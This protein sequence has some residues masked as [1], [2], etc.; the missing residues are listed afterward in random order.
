MMLHQSQSQIAKDLHRFRVVNCGRR[1]GKA[2]AI[3]TPI[4][5]TQGFKNLIDIEIGD[6]VFDENGKQV[7]V[8]YKSE[9]YNNRNCYA[10]TFSDGSVIIA[11]ENHDWLVED[12]SYRK[13]ITRSGKVKMVKLTTKQIQN[14]L[15]YG[16]ENNFS[17]PL[18]KPLEL[19][20]TSLSIE[21]YFLGLWLGDGSSD[22]CGITTIDKEVIDYLDKYADRLNCKLRIGGTG[23]AKT[24]FITGSRKQSDRNSSLQSKLRLL[25]VLNNKHIPEEFY[26]SSFE[27]RTELL[28]GL[29]DSDGYAGNNSNEY[30]TISKT[31]AQDVNKLL[32]SLSIK[33]TVKE[34]NSLFYGRIIGKKYRIHFNTDYEVFRLKRKLEK[35]HKINRPWSKRRY[36]TNVIGVGSVPV[37][38]LMVNSESHLFLAGYSLIPTHNTTLAVLEMVGKAVYNNDIQI[39][40]IAPTFDQAR[41]IAW[42]ELIKIVNQ[43]AI[44]INESRLEVT[45]R[46]TKGGKSKISLRGWEAV[47]RLRGKKF[48]FLVIDEIASM[49]NWDTNWEEVLR[50]TLTDTRGHAL[51]IST[52]KGFNH[53]Y[54]LFNKEKE[55]KDYK[56]F[57]YTSYDNP[58]LPVDE[59]DK[60]KTEMT[61]DRF[62]QEYLA[63]FR[64]MEGLVYKEFNRD[65]HLYSEEEVKIVPIEKFSGID[66]GYVNPCAVLTIIK[67][68]DNKFW[69]DDEFYKVKKSEE[70][71]AEYV[72]SQSFS[73]VYPDPEA[74]SAIEALRKKGVGVREVIKNRDSIKNGIDKIRELFKTNRLKINRRCVNLILELETYSYPDKK[75]LRNPDENPIKEN[76]HALDALRYALYMQPGASEIRPQ[77]KQHIPNNL[78]RRPIYTIN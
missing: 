65:I 75:D 34:Y 1:F 66:F 68:Y 64:K 56:S 78:S 24:Y 53:F 59:L 55:D 5:T 19:K 50:P 71:I 3:D 57:H 4:F 20:E 72:S 18:A 6:Y 41:D 49:R 52:P 37:Q 61:E 62:A 77:V 35:Q 30:T 7:E 38:C 9:I 33:S 45:L 63:D 51:F 16:K 2:L 40:Y 70:E 43:I 76:D 67:D 11:D 15:R 23:S 32:S 14:D 12:K 17:I 42:Q 21:P 48:D 31:L 27:Q 39:A 69:V 58:F 74:P 22:N 73:K 47:E 54:T 28:K 8:L 25:G 13:N 46:T 36:I 10:V 26:L 60:A 44:N 29:M